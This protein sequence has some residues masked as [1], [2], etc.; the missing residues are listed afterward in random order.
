M[1]R[2][3]KRK[4]EI[5]KDLQEDNFL[6]K[7]LDYKPPKPRLEGWICLIIGLAFLLFVIFTFM[8]VL[9]S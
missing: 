8:V 6:D 7:I 4:L 1:S 9:D 5:F 2:K 3:Y